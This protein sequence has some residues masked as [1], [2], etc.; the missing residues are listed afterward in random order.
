MLKVNDSQLLP[1]TVKP[2]LVWAFGPNTQTKKVINRVNYL[3]NRI[4]QVSFFGEFL[5]YVLR[6]LYMTV[7]DS[8]QI[9]LWVHMYIREQ[10]SNA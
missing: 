8:A 4:G 3:F 2:C 7:Y 1:R 5:I 10:K 9:D 6:K